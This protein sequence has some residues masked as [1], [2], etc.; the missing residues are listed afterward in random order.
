MDLFTSRL[1]FP[2]TAFDDVDPYKNAIIIA[3]IWVACLKPLFNADKVI[4][5]R[6]VH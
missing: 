2:A 1:S 3:Y 5:R 4:S 6:S